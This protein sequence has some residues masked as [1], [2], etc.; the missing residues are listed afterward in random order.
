VNTT[1]KG[2]AAE[3]RVASYLEDQGF[4][5]GG[6]RHRRG[7]GDLIAVLWDE[8]FVVHEVLLLEV[9]AT[10][11]SPW[12]TFGPKDRQELLETAEACGGRAVLAWVPTRTRL[13]LIYSK[14]WPS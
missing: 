8:E 5:V 14:D 7:G 9:K 2:S 6:R 4:V 13:E 10:K 11:R 1:S 3:N 12:Q